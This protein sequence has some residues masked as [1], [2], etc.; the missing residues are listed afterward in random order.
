MKQSP[1]KWLLANAAIPCVMV[2]LTVC[3]TEWHLHQ[4]VDAAAYWTIAHAWPDMSPALQKQA[5]YDVMCFR[6]GTLTNKDYHALIRA[7][8]HGGQ[9]IGVPGPDSDLNLA[10][11]KSAL[12]AAMATG[13]WRVA[14]GTQEH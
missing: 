4:E 8:A 3:A 14:D 7:A 13:K 5:R 1:W 9:M 6:R 12:C 11:E 10:H 2:I